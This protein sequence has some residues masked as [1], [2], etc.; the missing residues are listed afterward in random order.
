ME[1]YTDEFLNPFYNKMIEVTQPVI[2]PVLNPQSIQYVNF[3]SEA[4]SVFIMFIRD[5]YL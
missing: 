1:K 5:D 3:A 4:L 2:I